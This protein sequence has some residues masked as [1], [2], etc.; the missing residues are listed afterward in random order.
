MN[1]IDLLQEATL[2]AANAV[3]DNPVG[4]EALHR[5]DD[6]RQAMQ[7]LQDT[8]LGLLDL[9]TATELSAVHTLV[10]SLNQ[11]FAHL[12]DQLAELGDQIVMLSRLTSRI[13]ETIRIE[14]PPSRTSSLTV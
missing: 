5:A 2:K 8:I 1:P 12:E 10:R 7:Q 14:E 4:T 13:A 9:P 11:R 3:L 6:A